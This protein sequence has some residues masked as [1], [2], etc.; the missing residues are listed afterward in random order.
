MQL[1]IAVFGGFQVDGNVHVATA[2]FQALP[3]NE[4]IFADFQKRLNGPQRETIV[5]QPSIFRCELLVSGRVFGGFFFKSDS[6]SVETGGRNGGRGCV[7]IHIW[8]SHQRYGEE[9]VPGFL[10]VRTGTSISSKSISTK[11]IWFLGSTKRSHS[12]F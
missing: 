2:V 4:Q 11:E 8:G 7:W 10:F 6:L 9:F 3:K 5:F 12:L 1:E